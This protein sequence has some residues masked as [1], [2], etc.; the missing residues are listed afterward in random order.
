MK[1]PSLRPLFVSVVFLLAA[2]AQ[3]VVTPEPAEAPT[4]P[5]QEIWRPAVNTTW[6]WQLAGESIDQSLDVAM[7]DIDLFETDKSVVASLHE[8]GRI[9]VCYISAGSW[10]E[11]RPECSAVPVFHGRERIRRLARR[12]VV[13]HPPDRP[14]GAGHARSAGPMQG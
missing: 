7:Y 6:Q 11:W 9:V 10:E 13:G 8:R 3:P 5:A 2:C 1:S 12:E 14:A 4:P